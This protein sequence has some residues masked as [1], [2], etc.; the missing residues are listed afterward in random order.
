LRAYKTWGADDMT[1]WYLRANILLVQVVFCGIVITIE[2]II[3]D[4]DCHM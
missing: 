2:I 4:M 1:T 3:S